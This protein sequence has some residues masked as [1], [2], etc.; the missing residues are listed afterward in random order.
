[1]L[2]FRRRE[3]TPLDKRIIRGIVKKKFSDGDFESEN[4]SEADSNEYLRNHE[5]TKRKDD[6]YNNRNHTVQSDLYNRWD[7]PDSEFLGP[8]LF[9]PGIKVL[10]NL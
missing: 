4:E 3:L 10:S 1:M 2:Y 6:I 5:E 9:Q 7:T 8:K